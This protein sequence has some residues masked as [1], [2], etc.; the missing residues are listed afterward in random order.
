MNGQTDNRQSMNTPLNECV[1]VCVG[2]KCVKATSSSSAVLLTH[3]DFLAKKKTVELN[4]FF[5]LS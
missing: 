3:V 2:W 1:R 5:I 4:K